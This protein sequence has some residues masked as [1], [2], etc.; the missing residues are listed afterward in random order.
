VISF[1]IKNNK[2]FKRS[3]SANLP[4]TSELTIMTTPQPP[5]SG[6]LQLREDYLIPAPSPVPDAADESRSSVRLLAKLEVSNAIQTSDERYKYSFR[7]TGVCF[8]F[9]GLS[10]VE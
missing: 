10:P 9:H 5:D 8:S 4:G 7:L 3:A 6:H 2:A 1:Q